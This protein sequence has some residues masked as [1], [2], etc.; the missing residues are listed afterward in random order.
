[1][2]FKARMVRQQYFVV[3]KLDVLIGHNILKRIWQV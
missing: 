3:Y 2:R 1:M